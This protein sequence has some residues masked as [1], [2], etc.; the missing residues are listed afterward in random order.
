MRMYHPAVGAEIDVPDDPDCIA[1]HTDAGWEPA[2]EPVARPGYEPEPVRY[3]PVT[4]KA[5]R[6]T[7]KAD[8]TKAD[9]AD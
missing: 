6:S 3:E 5:T 9:K 7:K 8:D 4:T 2:P 1:V